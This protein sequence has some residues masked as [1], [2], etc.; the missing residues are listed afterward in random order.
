MK[1]SEIFQ[2]IVE[3]GSMTLRYALLEMLKKI[4]CEE[5]NNSFPFNNVAHLA[6]FI[7]IPRIK[8]KETRRKL[9]KIL[10]V[11]VPHTTINST[12][13][14][15]SMELDRKINMLEF[16]FCKFLFISFSG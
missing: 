15:N 5:R 8:K 13:P 9:R 16:A 2:R 3:I 7:N 11:N 14:Q 6:H 1:L 10:Y 4:I 12:I